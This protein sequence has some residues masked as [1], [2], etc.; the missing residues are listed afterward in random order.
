MIIK[1]RDSGGAVFVALILLLLST[2]SHATLTIQ[3]VKVVDLSG[4]TVSDAFVQVIEGSQ[5]TTI[6][7][8]NYC[9]GQVLL[10]GKTNSSGIAFPIAEKVENTAKVYLKAWGGSAPAEGLMYGYSRVVEVGDSAAM[11]DYPLASDVPIT[12]NLKASKPTASPTVRV[13]SESLVR[14]IVG[15]VPTKNLKVTLQT[16]ASKG[17]APDTEISSWATIASKKN[18]FDDTTATG[19]TGGQSATLTGAYFVG[20]TRY[21]IKT[22]AT[23]PFG[24]TSSAILPYDTLSLEGSSVG[25]VKVETIIETRLLTNEVVRT[26]VVTNEVTRYLT[27]EAKAFGFK[28]NLYPIA[29][30]KIIVN[31][32]AI[33]SSTLTKP[34]AMTVS[35]A[36]DLANAINQG[37]KDKIVRAIYTFDPANNTAIGAVFDTNGSFLSGT[38]FDIT[39]GIGYQVYLTKEV[40]D[41]VFEGK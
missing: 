8:G 27:G 32:I 28:F 31:S 35:R 30:G 19:N 14:E 29:Q 22:T 3:N 10:S 26:V 24:S 17:A 5:Q 4:A 13:V 12:L 21:Y 41:L 25:G 20:G 40:R 9:N 15:G 18:T 11:N 2:C 7:G 36:A 39:P 34:V 1:F 23:N 37:A 6:K 38:N 16:S 33:P